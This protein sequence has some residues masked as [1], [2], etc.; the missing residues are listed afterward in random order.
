MDGKFTFVDHRVINLMGYTPVIMIIIIFKIVIYTPVI[1][2]DDL[3]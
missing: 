1:N 2:I 3:D